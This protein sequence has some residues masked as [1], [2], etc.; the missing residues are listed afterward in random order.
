MRNVLLIVGLILCYT[1][2]S[3]QIIDDFQDADLNTAPTWS[4][5]L[6]AFTTANG[7]LKSNSNTANASFYLFTQFGLKGDLIWNIK[8]K[9]HFNTSSLNYT[10]VYLMADSMNL[11]KSVNAY[12][13]RL[14]G[15]QDEISLY[16]T[17]NQTSIK[18]LDGKDGI[19]NS[20]S[21]NL[22]LMVKR[23]GDTFSLSHLNLNSRLQAIEGSVYDASFDR[24]PYCGIVI[25]QST[26]S[27]FNKHYFDDLYIGPPI[28]DS[29]APR[30]DSV[31]CKN[32]KNID[33]YFSEPLDSFFMIKT[34]LFNL[35]GNKIQLDSITGSSNNSVWKLNFKS[36]LKPNY[37]Y[38]IAIDTVR[39][40][41]R[42]RNFNMSK[43]FVC[44]E[45][46]EPLPG[47]ILIDEIMADPEPS[48]GLPE[49]EY[50]ELR[51]V[52]NHF[53]SLE[54]CSIRDPGFKMELPP[55][56]LY[57]DSFFLIYNGPSLNNSG[58]HI[59]LYNND[60]LLHELT[61]NLDTYQDLNKSNGGY[62]LEMIDPY[63]ICLK[64]NWKASKDNRGGTPG[65]I[66]SV[67]Q[68]LPKDT[69]A[70]KIISVWPLE[71]RG[72]KLIVDELPDIK[73]QKMIHFKFNSYFLNSEMII[74][75]DSTVWLNINA[76]I[77]PDSIYSIII[78]G[79]I[80]C[81]GNSSKPDSFYVQWPSNSIESDMVF[82]E[83]LFNP[84][85]GGSDFI[86][87]Y[88]NSNHVLNLKELYIASLNDQG[89]YIEMY[90]ISEADQFIHPKQFLMITESVEMIC[91]QYNCGNSGCVKLKIKQL[92]SMPDDYGRLALVNAQGDFI[93]SMTYSVD[94]HFEK[95][96]DKEGI[97]LEKINPKVKSGSKFNWHSAAFSAGFAT[98]G[99]ENSQFIHEIKL[100]SPITVSNKIISPNSDGN[101]D[102]CVIQYNLNAADVVC[103]AEV[104]DLS[105][106]M[107][108]SIL[109]HK[110]I[111]NNG[112][113][114][115][116][117]T[118][119]NNQIPNTGIYI[120]LIELRYA[121]GKIS[122][123]HLTLIV[124]N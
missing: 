12:F 91:K 3:A 30:L 56:V 43:E 31:K 53:I 120:L 66:N 75:N 27:F 41:Y 10:D 105:G 55:I 99:K 67:D 103:T 90:R 110:T 15:S 2:T 51:N 48:V 76:P 96:D 121:D 7:A 123:E 57:P 39:D 8:I 87:F 71:S 17:V 106:Q 93:D 119:E 101:N 54:N 64:N 58:D 38:E 88:N 4:G 74:Q 52:S 109:N 112:Q 49:I 85:S 33:L 21:N 24:L 108:K 20:S 59:G 73:K 72:L 29:I 1:I 92:P 95:L 35:N 26:S 82:N 36:Q 107:I 111:G 62:S 6:S 50:I 25:R 40:L 118:D 86:E 68:R 44:I 23:N 5:M 104:Y 65:K 13:V 16:K 61:Y 84:K 19:L 98:P 11:T 14:G 60:T 89:F 83:V 124:V 78:N 102:L 122:K 116:D 22:E 42:N 63:Q 69:S 94:W 77:H 9:L 80:D 117:G 28:K 114:S 115:W 45:A 37:F 47:D 113:F 79:L 34:S 100:E 97:S 70:P 46:I 81:S 18:I 32:L